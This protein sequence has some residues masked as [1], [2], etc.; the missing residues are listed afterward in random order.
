MMFKC[1][2]GL[3]PDYLTDRFICS[4]QVHLKNTRSAAA[5]KVIVK[6]TRGRRPRLVSGEE[7]PNF[8][9]TYLDQ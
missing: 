8:G 6:N 1:L 3:A 9:M 4:A 2:N 7:E 5:K